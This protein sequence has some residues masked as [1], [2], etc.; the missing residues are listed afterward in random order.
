MMV[1]VW[2]GPTETCVTMPVTLVATWLK[3]SERGLGPR[4]CK[5]MAA[6]WLLLP[7][8][9]RLAPAPPALLLGGDGDS[10][11]SPSC[12]NAE[13]PA[14]V[15]LTAPSAPRARPPAR[16]TVSVTSVSAGRCQPSAACPEQDVLNK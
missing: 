9:A 2:L 8:S 7:L 12:W 15:P 6:E 4:P 10:Q 13:Q 16:H 11:P 14:A 5:A 1:G 3:Q